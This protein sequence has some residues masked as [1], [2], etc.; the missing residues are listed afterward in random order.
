LL[1]QEQE[2]AKGATGTGGLGLGVEV[3]G[4]LV[5]GSPKQMGIFTKIEED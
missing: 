2:G 4:Q 5:V 3:P 1:L